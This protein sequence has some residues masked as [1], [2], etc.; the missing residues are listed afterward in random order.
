MFDKDLYLNQIKET[1]DYLIKRGLVDINYVI[2]LGSGLG[3]IV[4]K[5]DVKQVVNYSDIPNFMTTTVQGHKGKLVYC[6]Y[7]NLNI[8]FMQ[9]RFHYYEG[10]PMYKVVFPIR[11]FSNMGVSNLIVTN[12]SGGVNPNF[13]VGDVMII[14]DHVAFFIPENPLRG[15]NL[16]NFGPRFLDMQN[17]YDREWREKVKKLYSDVSY[18]KEGVYC[19]VSGPNYETF[20]ELKLLKILEID[21]VGMSTVPEVI[22]A[23][24]CGMKVIGFSVITDIMDEVIKSG[25]SHEEVLE[26]TKKA[27]LLIENLIKTAIENND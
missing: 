1:S 9:G 27:T 2:V 19:M 3:D 21:A 14:K 4:E 10:Y 18:V 13:K 6:S 8:V 12:A 5:F 16:D 23:R 24:H 7:K 20:S 25:V 11:V 15:P 17:A 26:N 22:V